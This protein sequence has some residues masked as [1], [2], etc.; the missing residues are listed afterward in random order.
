VFLF[1]HILA[2]ICCPLRV[3]CLFVCYLS[4]SG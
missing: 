1:F 4:H 3:V 2:S